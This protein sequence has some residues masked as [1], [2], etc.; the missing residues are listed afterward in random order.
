MILIDSQKLLNNIDPQMVIK[1]MKYL[2]FSKT[3]IA[4]LK[5]YLSEQ[6]FKKISTLVT[7]AYQT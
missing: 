6:K 4:W 5:S 2:Q 7:P 3:V 1:K